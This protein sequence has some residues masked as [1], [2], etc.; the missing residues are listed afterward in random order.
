GCAA[1]AAH[2]GAPDAGAAETNAR[3]AP[4]I[5]M[6]KPLS[7][8]LTEASP[9]CAS[10]RVIVQVVVGE[11]ASDDAYAR[12]S[13]ETATHSPLPAHEVAVSGALATTPVGCH[14][15]AADGE[16]DTSRRRPPATTRH[17]SARGQERPLSLAATGAG[18][19]QAKG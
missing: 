19:D 6:Q 8:Q 2:S 18:K 15:L 7:A 3:P 1:D 17:R 9:S 13:A 4:S 10:M 11:A 16:V 14:E 12:P 5:A